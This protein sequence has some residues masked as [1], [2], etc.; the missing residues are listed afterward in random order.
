MACKKLVADSEVD[1]AT[2]QEPDQLHLT[3]H[4]SEPF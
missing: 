2:F 4:Q 1:W 3:K